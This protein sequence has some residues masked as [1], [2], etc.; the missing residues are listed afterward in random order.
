MRVGEWK[1]TRESVTPPTRSA[2]NRASCC[3]AAVPPTIATFEPA[4]GGPA[5]AVATPPASRREALAT[6]RPAAIRDCGGT[7]CNLFSPCTGT[8]R[9]WYG[10]RAAGSCLCPDQFR[11][12]RRPRGW[13]RTATGLDERRFERVVAAA[14]YG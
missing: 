8:V 3:C 7:A 14:A 2:V 13:N 6:Q 1:T 5:A 12:L 10:N 11:R 9:A 4:G